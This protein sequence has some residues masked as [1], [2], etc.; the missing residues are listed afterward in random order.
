MIKSAISL[1]PAA[2]AW[3]NAQHPA[4]P[5]P[6]FPADKA[7]NISVYTNLK[8]MKTDGAGGL[9]CHDSGADGSDP[10]RYP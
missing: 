9:S 4:A 1:F 10:D 5:V 6:A 8:G 3:A 2:S 7:V